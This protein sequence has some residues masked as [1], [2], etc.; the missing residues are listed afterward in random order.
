MSF[1]NEGREDRPRSSKSR[2]CIRSPRTRLRR[3]LRP[4]TAVLPAFRSKTGFTIMEVILALALFAVAVAAFSGA[5]VNILNAFEAVK[6]DQSFEQDLSLVRKQ[7]LAIADVD[8]LE[9]GGEVVTGSHGIANWTV[10]YE[11]TEVAD[12]FQVTLLVEL[13]PPDSD[14]AVQVEQRLFL[15]RPTWSEPVERETLRAETAKRLEQRKL[16]L[17]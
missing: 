5:Y 16:G 11:A 4:G 9:E 14:D 6:L 8:E 3:R 12:L 15:T 17:E 7:V 10:E 1:R 2:E 13:Y